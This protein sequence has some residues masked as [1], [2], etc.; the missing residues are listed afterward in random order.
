[1][2]P[3][4]NAAILLIAALLTPV[5]AHAQTGDRE[6]AVVINADRAEYSEQKQQQTLTGNV[7]ITQGSLKIEADKIIVI[8]DNGDLG[9]MDAYGQPARFQQLDDNGELT[10]GQGDHIAYSSNN[11]QLLIKKNARLNTPQQ[12]LS[13]E[14]IDYNINTHSARAEGG[15]GRVNIIFQPKKETS[16]KD[17]KK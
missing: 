6:Q 9:H 13:G 15:E 3:H 4:L 1:M 16:Q 7:T 17:S 8:L 10:R 11:G 5:L 14:E 12:A 2:K